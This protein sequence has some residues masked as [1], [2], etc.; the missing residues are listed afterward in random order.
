ME[1][2][3]PSYDDF[4]LDVNPLQRPY[5][6][7]IHAYLTGQGCTVKVQSAKSG[8]VVSFVFGAGSHTVANFIIR[9]KGA[10]IRIYGDH[11]EAYQDVLQAL[12]EAMQKAVEKASVCRRLLDPTKCNARCPMGNVFTLNGTEH[13]KCRYNNFI[14]FI[15][16]ESCGPLETFLTR[17][18][19]ARTA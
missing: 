17:E 18:M 2:E 12:P 14:F 16:E 19:A 11:V 8:P 7:R 9:K 13:K 10:M 6:D 3:N 15:D 1:K 5:V 4:L